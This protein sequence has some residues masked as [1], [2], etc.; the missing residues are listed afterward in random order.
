[1]PE[2][3]MHRR[4]IGGEDLM[5]TDQELTDYYNSLPES[6]RDM[7]IE[8]F[9]QQVHR[10]MNPRENSEMLKQM[11]ADRQMERTARHNKAVADKALE[12]SRAGI[13]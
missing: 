1:M 7:P 6:G 11:M 12:R 2:L 4:K 10:I 5:F 8:T 13:R 9:K 3:Y